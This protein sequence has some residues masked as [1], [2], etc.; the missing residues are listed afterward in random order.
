MLAGQSAELDPIG[1][2][3]GAVAIRIDWRGSGPVDPWTGRTRYKTTTS[4]GGS[5]SHGHRPY[6]RAVNHAHSEALRRLVAEASDEEADGVVD[7]DHHVVEHDDGLLEVVLR[8]TAVRA[9][10]AQRPGRVF[11]T[12]LGAGQ[13]GTLIRQHWVPVTAVWGF[14]VGVRPTDWSAAQQRRRSAPP[15]EVVGRSD[16]LT[17]TRADAR[18]QLADRARRAGADG[19]LTSTMTLRERSEMVCEALI[20]GTAIAR[21]A[22]GDPTPDDIAPLTVMPLR[23]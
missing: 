4:G 3:T 18:D 15:Q 8:G 14:S 12:D 11:T 9:R 17:R 22:P 6:A 5:G 19:I 7:L 1:D 23:S 21:F 13:V 2:V 16:L 10:T 20:R